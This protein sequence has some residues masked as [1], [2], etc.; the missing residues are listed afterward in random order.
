MP[1]TSTALPAERLT[2]A[3]AGVAVAVAG[4]SDSNVPVTASARNHEERWNAPVNPPRA[5][6]RMLDPFAG[7]GID[8]Q[9][10]RAGV[11]VR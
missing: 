2:G 9:V 8:D 5:A 3:V 10:K 4:E 1:A 7:G 11:N 6:T